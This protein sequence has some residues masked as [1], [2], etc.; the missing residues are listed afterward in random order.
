M[1]SLPDFA[2]GIRHGLYWLRSHYWPRTKLDSSSD[3]NYYLPL[4][5]GRCDA[6][7]ATE[8][9]EHFSQSVPER[10]EG[11]QYRSVY[12]AFP[13]CEAAPALI[14]PWSKRFISL[15]QNSRASRPVATMVQ[16]LIHAPRAAFYAQR[17]FSNDG[18]ERKTQGCVNV[19]MQRSSQKW[20][21]Q[22]FSETMPSNWSSSTDS[23]I[24]RRAPTAS[25]KHV[26]PPSLP[27]RM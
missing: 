9:L 5:K 25:M 22:Q 27:D 13:F 21:S 12:K 11:A 3:P 26:G 18:R 4:C 19:E 2:P 24:D 8:T 1:L 20:N 6:R 17:F 14:L 7:P 15:G 16:D 23:A 10:Y